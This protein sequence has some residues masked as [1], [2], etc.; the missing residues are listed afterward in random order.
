MITRMFLKMMIY[1]TIGVVSINYLIDAR[2]QI[3]NFVHPGLATAFST[4]NVDEE[5]ML[6]SHQLLD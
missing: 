4:A 1:L 2:M 5:G 6:E 3:A